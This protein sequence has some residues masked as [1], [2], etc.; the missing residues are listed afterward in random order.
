MLKV[1]IID[2]IGLPYDGDTLNHQGLGGSESAVILM[3]QALYKQGFEVDVYCNCHLNNHKPGVYDGVTYISNDDQETKNRKSYDVVV[4]SRQLEPFAPDQKETWPFALKAG[5]RVAWMHDVFLQGDDEYLEEFILKGFVHE[6][7]TLSDFHTNFVANAVYTEP[8]R[9]F[10]VTKNHF[11]QTRNGAVKYIEDVDVTKKDKNHFIFNA[12][13]FKG[14]ENLLLKVWPRVKERL[15]DAYL[16]VVGGSYIFREGYVDTQEE[17]MRAAV[18][19][20]RNKELDVRFTG[21]MRQKDIAELYANA[22]MFLYPT[23]IP[24]TFGISALESL[25]YKTPL[26]TN[27]HGALES[28]ALDGACYKVPYPSSWNRLLPDIDEQ[29]QLEKFLDVFF[30]AYEDEYLHQQKQQYCSIIDNVYSWDSIAL[31]WK[32]RFFSK[33]H[34]PL[35]V[36]EYRKVKKINNEVARIFNIRRRNEDDVRMYHKEHSSEKRIVV[37]SPFWNAEK[38]IAQNILSVAQQDYDNYIHLLIDDCSEDNSYNVAVETLKVLPDNL[39]EKFLLK[40]NTENMGAIFNQLDTIKKLNDDD[41]VVLL[42]GD[43]WLVNNNTIFNHYNNLYHQGHDF[44]Y[45][46][47]MSVIQNIPLIA[48]EYPKTVIKNKSYRQHKFNWGIPYTHLRTFSK[49]LANNIDESKFKRDGDWMR[50]GADNP[51]FYELIERSENPLAVK[52]IVCYYNDAHEYN[53][54]KIR[55]EEQ[56]ENAGITKRKDKPAENKKILIAFP[57]QKYIE[58]ETFKSIYDLEIPDGYETELEYFYGYQVDQIRNYIANWGKDYDYVL[59]VDYDM[60]L[61][62]DTLTKFIEADKDI[63]SGIYIQRRDEEHLVEIFEDKYNN[64]GQHRM[65]YENIKDRGVFEISGCGFGCVLVKGDVYRKV[66][67][68]HFE[69]KSSLNGDEIVSEDSYFCKKAIQHG[70]KVWADSSVICD[71][72]GTTIFKV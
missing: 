17:A 29:D 8:R 51:L 4:A 18:A 71:H 49:K 67:Y 50:A 61:P 24:E 72:K 28:T 2:I 42:D 25:L 60:I 13:Y 38:F 56:N 1:A 6:I 21:V 19:D 59:H 64:G 26:M 35:P 62:K 68:P 33:L 66:P 63:I 23:D 43:D 55:G 57:T 12:A 53:D 44:T 14:L 45:G 22:Y 5:Y 70:F 7:Y 46:S 36:D 11:W 3:A 54:Y 30:R 32:Q 40:R 52:E 34:I 39:R 31:Q 16:T 47:M 69:Y 27:R 58:P 48:Q 41:I 20:P 15:P 9:C 10:E 37:I 65:S